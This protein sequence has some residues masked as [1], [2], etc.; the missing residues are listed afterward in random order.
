MNL[1]SGIK[2]VLRNPLYIITVLNG[3][4]LLSWIPDKLFLQLLYMAYMG[5]RLN[6]NNPKLFTEKLQWLKLYNRNPEH[7]KMVDKYEVRT[8]ITEKYGAEYLIPLLGVWDN[9]EEINFS[10]LPDQFILKCTND[11]GTFVICTDK[12]EFNIDVA[13]KKLEKRL[14]YNYYLL[15]REY[16]YKN[17]KPRIICEK[18]MVDESG[19]EL[20]DYKVFCFGGKPAYIL[21]DFNR[22]KGH[23]RNIYDTKWQYVPFVMNR[24]YPD[25]SIIFN[26]PTCCDEMLDIARELS[27][28][29]PFLRVDFYI[30][31]NRLYIGE[32]TFFP[33]TGLIIFEPPEY[34]TILGRLLELPDITASRETL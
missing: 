23:N 34:N 16:P 25:P 24:Y 15:H 11:S 1:L 5:Q 30:V 27:K 10:A 19:T 33:G 21:V 4:H 6:L 17:V 22:T 14:K 8:F 26:K 31:E 2:K 3:L 20:K 28:N 18:Y 7:T 9:F 12:N 13:K 32:L 29:H